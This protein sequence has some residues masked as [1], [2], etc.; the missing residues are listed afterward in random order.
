MHK[1]LGILFASALLTSQVGEA[2]ARTAPAAP[3]PVVVPTA[4]PPRGQ[5]RYAGAHPIASRPNAGYCY[6]DVPHMHDY[7]P[8]RPELYQQVGAGYVFVGD[9]T[10]FGYQGQKTVYYGHH[11]VP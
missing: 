10:P 1:L 9:P 3:A 11:P 8:D 5:G 2:L 7:L 4:P 6:I